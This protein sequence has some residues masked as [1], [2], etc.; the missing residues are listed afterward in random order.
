MWL[1]PAPQRPF[2]AFR[3]IYNFRWFWDYSGG[4]MTN[5]GHHALDIMHW[6]LGGKLQAVSSSGGRFALEDNGETPDTQDALF[7][8][9][10]DEGG[11]RYTAV[12]SHREAAGVPEA[13]IPIELFGTKGSLGISRRS[14]KITPD[15][16][17]PPENRV[18]QYAGAHPVGGPK[19][20]EAARTDE[21][22]TTPL[23]DS[24]SERE[25]FMGHVRNFVDCV[26]SRSTPIS[27]LESAHRASTM[28]HLA[29]LSLRVGR[30]LRWDADRQT[31]VD[32]APASDM[33]T[34]PYRAPWGAELRALGV[35]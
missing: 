13:P 14:F 33:L 31:V 17:V 23:E 18:P 15:K 21:Y 30:K 12:W 19:R 11:N 28:C 10:S 6:Y 35:S 8:I 4:Q 22:W 1:G 2:D 34:R 27:D 25:Q 16:K 3:C 29:N 9:A 5:L 7:E 26:K 24:G 32:D 20:V